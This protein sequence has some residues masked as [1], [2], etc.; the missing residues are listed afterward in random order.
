M[1]SSKWKS[2]QNNKLP[3]MIVTIL[4]T[5]LT[6]YMK[7]GMDASRSWSRCIVLTQD[8][9]EHQRFDV[10]A[11]VCRL[12]VL[13]PLYTFFLINIV[14]CK[15]PRIVVAICL[16]ETEPISEPGTWLFFAVLFQSDLIFNI[17]QYLRYKTT[18]TT[19]VD[20]RV[21]IELVR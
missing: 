17:T 4:K 14:F 9:K 5:M 6:V 19:A 12:Y 13:L 21:N 3:E 16:L 10:S 7:I 8:V 2:P 1:L 15:Y 20:C 18:G 11:F